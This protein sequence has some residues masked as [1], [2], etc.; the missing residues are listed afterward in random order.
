MDLFDRVSHGKK[1]QR[2][3]LNLGN[4]QQNYFADFQEAEEI[5]DLCC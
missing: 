4:M 3:P 1:W 2:F 5:G